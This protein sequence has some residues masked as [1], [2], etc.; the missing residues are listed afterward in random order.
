MFLATYLMK[1]KFAEDYENTLIKTLSNLQKDIQKHEAESSSTLDEAAK[2]TWY[3]SAVNSCLKPGEAHMKLSAAV[4]DEAG[5]LLAKS[6]NVIGRT[7][8]LLEA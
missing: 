4:Y 6:T 5:R 3:Q 1:L 8:A 7:A 2:R